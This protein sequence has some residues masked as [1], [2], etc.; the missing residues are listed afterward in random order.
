MTKQRLDGVQVWLMIA[1]LAESRSK[2]G[3]G[4]KPSSISNLRNKTRLWGTVLI[5]YKHLRMDHVW[6][7]LI[8]KAN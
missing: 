4:V 3:Q 2:T 1:S 5:Y 6:T 8:S 7:Y